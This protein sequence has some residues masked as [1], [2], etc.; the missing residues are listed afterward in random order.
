ML[1]A[2]IHA[3]I[4]IYTVLSVVFRLN[5]DVTATQVQSLFRGYLGRQKAKLCSKLKDLN[6]TT[7]DWIEVRDRQS[8]DVWFYNKKNGISQWERPADMAEKVSAAE[9]VK[10]L[11]FSLLR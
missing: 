2:F 8:G 11:P 9:N 5:A 7:S 10:R 6:E 3:C 4:L 1:D